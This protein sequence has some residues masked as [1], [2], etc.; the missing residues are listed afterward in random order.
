MGAGGHGA[1]EAMTVTDSARE[2]DW[3]VPGVLNPGEEV[4]WKGHCLSRMGQQRKAAPAAAGLEAVLALALAVIAML[5]V[6]VITR[7]VVLGMAAFLVTVLLAV[8]KTNGLL[9]GWGADDAMYCRQQTVYVLTNQRA[10]VLRNC[11]TAHPVQSLLWTY[12][13]EVQA[14]RV[15]LDGRGTVQ[16][17]RWDPMEQRWVY[18]LRFFKVANAQAVAERA[19]AAR[20]AARE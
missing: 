2:A 18:S 6:L 17:L 19:I 20:D 13:D 3:V 5:A 8:W 12:V 1:G 10:V 11:R 15:E 14:E 4:L 9:E 7:I 16:F